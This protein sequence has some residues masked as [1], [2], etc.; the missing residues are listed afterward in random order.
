M[1]RKTLQRGLDDWSAQL[2]VTDLY[3]QKEWTKEEVDRELEGK[4][5]PMSSSIHSF[6]DQFLFHPEDVP[7]DIEQ[8]PEVFTVFR[9]KCEKYSKVRACFPP[10]NTMGK[11]NLLPQEFYIPSLEDLGLKRN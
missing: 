1:G 3:F 8:L 6:Y 2:G 9:K 7:M 11:E 4:N 10:L 5:R